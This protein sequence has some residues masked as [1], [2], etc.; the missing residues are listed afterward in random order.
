MWFSNSTTATKKTLPCVRHRIACTSREKI[1]LMG[2][3]PEALVREAGL[4][5]RSGLF[6]VE[7]LVCSRQKGLCQQRQVGTCGSC[8]RTR[9]TD[10]RLWCVVGQEGAKITARRVDGT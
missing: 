6:Y 1:E 10:N 8:V 7:K 3:E 2:E 4:P 5:R 9:G